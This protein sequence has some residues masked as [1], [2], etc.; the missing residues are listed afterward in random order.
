MREIVQTSQFKRDLKRLRKRG[1][2]LDRIA[3]IIDL[4][5]RDEKLPERCRPH[6]LVGEFPGL[7]ECHI[8]PDWLLIY[9]LAPELLVLVASGTHADLFQ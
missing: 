5:V 7:W 9:D 3:R 8:E 1:Y 4:L 2:S 6:R